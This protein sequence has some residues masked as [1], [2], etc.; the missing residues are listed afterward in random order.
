MENRKDLKKI[1]IGLL[2]LLGIAPSV[3]SGEPKDQLQQTTDKVLTILSDPNLKSPEKTKERRQLILKAVDERF[4]WEE[5]ARRCLG[6]H[7]SKR[8]SE[9]KR[10]FVT[11][12]KELLQR[13]YMDKVEGYSWNRIQYE[14]ER[15]DGDYSIVKVKIFTPKDQPIH[16]EY[17]LIKKKNA[18]WVYDFVV[19]GVSLVNNY[20]TQFNEIIVKSSYKEL[21]QRLKEKISKL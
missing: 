2:I 20:R 16:V 13:V 18:W 21:I 10:E 7:W 14:G 15:I 17:R 9:E 4:D 6:R 11:I 1:I 5:M 12:F 8:T 3:L 19:E